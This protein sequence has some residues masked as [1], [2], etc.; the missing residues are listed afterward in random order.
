LEYQECIYKKLCIV[1]SKPVE[2]TAPAATLHPDAKDVKHQS[3]EKLETIQAP[4]V[5]SMK[6]KR[7]NS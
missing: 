3:M 7:A 6:K 4:P 1:E 5:R 2:T